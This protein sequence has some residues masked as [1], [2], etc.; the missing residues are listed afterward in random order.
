MPEE[1]TPNPPKP[2][3]GLGE[4]IRAKRLYTGLS[5]VGFARQ[6]GVADRQYDRIETESRG[7]LCPTGFIDSIDA[8][9]DRFDREVQEMIETV[10]ERTVALTVSDA[11]RNEWAR[12]VLGRAAVHTPGITPTLVGDVQTRR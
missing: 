4:L 9:L 10:G 6:L 12:A 1:T 8:V 7:D 11:P 3:A 2:T 5:K